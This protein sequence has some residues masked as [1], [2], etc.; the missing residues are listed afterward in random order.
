MHINR[1]V[2]KPLE[3]NNK[4][5]NFSLTTGSFRDASIL[6]FLLANFSPPFAR[7]LT[8]LKEG[9]EEKHV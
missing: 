1:L 3:F 7:L 2:L 5:K 9:F 6:I 8:F 4:K